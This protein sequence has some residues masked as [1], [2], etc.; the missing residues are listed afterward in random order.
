MITFLPW[1]VSCLKNYKTLYSCLIFAF[2]WNLKVLTKA[3]QMGNKTTIL[4]SEFESCHQVAK[5]EVESSKQI[6]GL[7]KRKPHF[8]SFFQSNMDLRKPRRYYCFCTRTGSFWL[9]VACPEPRRP[10]QLGS[11]RPAMALPAQ[12]G[13]GSSAATCMLAQVHCY[14]LCQTQISICKISS[15]TRKEPPIYKSDRVRSGVVAYWC[16]RKYI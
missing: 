13:P 12:P 10:C 14:E 11:A 9:F 4:I 7:K 16:K 15:C 1:K 2:C 5:L 6:Q 8:Y 3:V